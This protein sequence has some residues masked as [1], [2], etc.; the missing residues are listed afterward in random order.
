VKSSGSQI[1]EVMVKGFAYF[2]ITEPVSGNDTSVHG[3]FIKLTGPGEID[4]HALN[5]GAY[6][7]RLTE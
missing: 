6:S 7:I 2:Y 3:M 5:R 4:E 1:K